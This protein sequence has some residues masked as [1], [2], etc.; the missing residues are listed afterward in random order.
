MIRT[1][2]FSGDLGAPAVAIACLLAL[3]GVAL[4]GVELFWR[5]RRPR[6]TALRIA[7]TGVQALGEPNWL[8]I[9]LLRSIGLETRV[10]IAAVHPHCADA[11]PVYGHLAGLIDEAASR[12]EM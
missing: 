6:G 8:V 3:L 7:A 10:T 1:L 12:V 5:A 9:W 2:S 11:Q 4:L